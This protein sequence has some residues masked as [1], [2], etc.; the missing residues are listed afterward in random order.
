MCTADKRV[1]QLRG[2]V[3]KHVG[4]ASPGWCLSGSGHLGLS[5]PCARCQWS[6]GCLFHAATAA[7][8]TALSCK[9]TAGHSSAA[10]VSGNP[11]CRLSQ[12]CHSHAATAVCC[13]G[14]SCKGTAGTAV[15]QRSAALT[16]ASAMTACT[17]MHLHIANNRTSSA[18][19]N[20]CSSSSCH[21]KFKK[22]QGQQPTNLPPANHTHHTYTMQSAAP[23]HAA[24]THAPAPCTPR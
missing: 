16:D 1:E 10:T 5:A 23:A 9:A 24:Q 22:A 8:R 17:A 11:C 7:R 13:S 20:M 14:P 18:C 2:C 6:Q 15:R 19:L 4:A 12:D 3:H 21:P